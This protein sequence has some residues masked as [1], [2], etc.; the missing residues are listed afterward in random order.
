MED[1]LLTEMPFYEVTDAELE[2]M[3]Y[4]DAWH[5]IFDNSDLCDCVNRIHKV[6]LLNNLI[7]SM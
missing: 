7:S 5:N 6:L 2:T 3:L 1:S 4:L